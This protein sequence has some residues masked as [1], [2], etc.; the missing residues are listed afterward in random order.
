MG[1]A[2]SG[3]PEQDGAAVAWD[4][5]AVEEADDGGLGALPFLGANP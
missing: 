5:V 2:D 4:E 1:F 3:R